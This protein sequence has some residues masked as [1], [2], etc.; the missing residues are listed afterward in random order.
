MWGFPRSSVSLLLFHLCSSFLFSLCSLPPVP[1]FPSPLYVPP[2]VRL[3]VH[4]S[5]PFY[6]PWCSFFCSLFSA[7]LSVPH[8]LL[9]GSCSKSGGGY[10]LPRAFQEC[11]RGP[12]EHSNHKVPMGQSVVAALN[13][14]LKVFAAATLWNT[15]VVTCRCLGSWGCLNSLQIHYVFAALFAAN[16]SVG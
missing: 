3:S 2:F 4:P 8:W 9:I 15:L 12:S 11:P 10:E 16:L 1:P 6:H 14:S 5:A 7:P 13:V